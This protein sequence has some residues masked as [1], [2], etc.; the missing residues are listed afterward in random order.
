[1]TQDLVPPSVVVDTPAHVPSTFVFG[2]ASARVGTIIAVAKTASCAHS[3]LCMGCSP[4]PFY[5]DPP[6][7]AAG[8]NAG[9]IQLLDSAVTKPTTRAR[10]VTGVLLAGQPGA[11]AWK[12]GGPRDPGADTWLGLPSYASMSRM[13][14]APAP[15][16]RRSIPTRYCSNCREGWG[17]MRTDSK[18]MRLSVHELVD[19]ANFDPDAYLA[20]NADLAA[21]RARDPA[22]ARGCSTGTNR[23]R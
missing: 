2:C 17:K 20:A 9:S 23:G 10:S 12:L 13:R 7:L 16:E 1:M 6:N 19:E 11:V 3:N 5:D 14:P 22:A 8:K 15:T 4:C 18:P 21:A